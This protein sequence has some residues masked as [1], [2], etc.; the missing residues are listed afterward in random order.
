MTKTMMAAAIA[1]AML[2]GCSGGATEEAA[3]AGPISLQAGQWEIITVVESGRNT[4]TGKAVFP[5]EAGATETSKVCLAAADA[6]KPQPAFFMPSMTSCT[7]TN[8][9]FSDGTLQAQISCRKDGLN[10][11]IGATVR[12]S[13]TATTI[14]A[15]QIVET[16]LAS[17]GDVSIT[18]KL[19]GKRIGDCPAG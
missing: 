15:Q 1:V 13:Y 6:A 11:A 7:Y 16:Q 3:P 2:A 19:T 9:Y 17:D 18:S 5:I 14:D 4:D 12:G 10:G 8:D